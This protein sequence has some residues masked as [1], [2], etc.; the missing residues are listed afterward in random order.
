MK[1]ILVGAVLSCLP[2]A[3]ALAEISLWRCDLAPA[4]KGALLFSGVLLIAFDEATG[5]AWAQ[6]PGVKG[7]E[8][9]FVRVKLAEKGG[10]LDM[11]WQ[12]R[13]G[14][15]DSADIVRFSYRAGFD[16]GGSVISVRATILEN[17]VSPSAS[18]R[19]I[20]PVHPH[21]LST[22]TGPSQVSGPR[23]RV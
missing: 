10:S 7:L 9:D 17:L 19:F 11:R 21:E 14:L 2:L 8:K 6:D 23:K 13:Y 5:Q 4:V 3:P 18:G 1:A 16:P 15:A 20:E 22:V 12:V